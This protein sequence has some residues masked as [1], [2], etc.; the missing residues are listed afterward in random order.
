MWVVI[1]STCKQILKSQKK[2]EHLENTFSGEAF[3]STCPSYDSGYKAGV[4]L[5][6][7]LSCLTST[8]V[9][10]D[11]FMSLSTKQQLLKV[12]EKRQVVTD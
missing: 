12:K 4:V 2:R 1:L 8:F 11:V 5:R 10:I 3:L 7:V 6:L 9:W